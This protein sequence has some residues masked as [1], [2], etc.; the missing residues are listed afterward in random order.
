MRWAAC[1]EAPMTSTSSAGSS[2]GL[3]QVELHLKYMGCDYAL[4]CPFNRMVS[5]MNDCLTGL[6]MDCMTSISNDR[7]T[8]PMVNLN[9]DCMIGLLIVLMI[10][11][12]F[13]LWLV[14]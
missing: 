5:L 10:D 7:M 13:P 14:L 9:N 1:A 6:M 8:G 12:S 2:T 4:C 11:S 3:L